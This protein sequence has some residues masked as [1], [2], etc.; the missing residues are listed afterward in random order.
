MIE[1][2][3]SLRTTL[4][5]N[6]PSIAELDFA[7]GQ[8]LFGLGQLDE[9]RGKFQA[10]VDARSGGDLA[11]HAQYLRGET[12]FHQDRFHD[13][14]REFLK[15]DILYNAPHW[16]AVS[17]LE[18]G[19]VYERLDQWTDAAETYDR[20]CTKFPMDSIAA[21][22]KTRLEAAKRRT[23]KVSRSQC[24]QSD[25][26]LSHKSLILNNFRKSDLSG[27]MPFMRGC[28]WTGHAIVPSI[29]GGVFVLL[30]VSFAWAGDGPDQIG[31]T[32]AKGDS[33]ACRQNTWE[34]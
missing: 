34:L 10:V 19:K 13:A 29:A 22:A 8:A 12:Y 20:L 28:K 11:A 23:R 5:A 31:R 2:V 14:L 15:V 6:D 25:E 30:L 24:A 26:F 3:Q 16:Q 1:R 7:E 33:N 17:L 4:A 9:A 27:R 18:A 32:P 21:E